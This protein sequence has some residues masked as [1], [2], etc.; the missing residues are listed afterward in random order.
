MEKLYF[1]Y[2]IDST[3]PIPY[4]F[5]ELSKRIDDWHVTTFTKQNNDIIGRENVEE[6]QILP[7][8]NT[9]RRRI[10]FGLTSLHNY[11]LLHTGG[12]PQRH[13]R[14]SKISHSRN[15]KLNHVHTFRVDID[16]ESEFEKLEYKDKLSKMANSLTAVSEHTAQ[17]VEEHLGISPRVIYN[18][19][20][21]NVF[22]PDYSRPEIYDTLGIRGPIFLY[23]GSFHSRKNPSHVL[24]VADHVEEATFLM[25][26]DGPLFENLR[27]R[28]STMD[29]V[30]LTGKLSKESLPPIYANATGFLFPTIRE[31]CPN[32]VLEA[33][34]SEL[35]VVGY[36]ATSMPELVQDGQSGYLVPPT[37]IDELTAAIA[38]LTRGDRH[39]EMGQAAREYILENHTFDTV[40]KQ[41]SEVYDELL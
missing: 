37:D 7:E 4:L 35:P 32:V 36:R 13:Y 21:T 27:K 28:A 33:M 31:G 18:G 39:Q 24:E 41:Y 15:T 3:S 25:I 38:A 26:G 6:V 30:I 11:D 29:N 16:P 8:G 5:N 10:R 1:P 34:A 14:I 12:R 40:S 22:R 23:V 9:W 2:E 17:T 20:D 19:V